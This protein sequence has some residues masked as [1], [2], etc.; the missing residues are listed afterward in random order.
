MAWQAKK[1]KVGKQKQRQCRSP[2]VGGLPHLHRPGIIM[3]RMVGTYL[4]TYYKQ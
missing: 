1:Y 2:C 3:L 4:G